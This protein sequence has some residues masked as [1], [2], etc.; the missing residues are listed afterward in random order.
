[1]VVHRPKG[2][3]DLRD[4]IVHGRVTLSGKL[5]PLVNKVTGKAGSL[6]PD[7]QLQYSMDYFNY[8]LL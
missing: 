6:L 7:E 8:F 5:C 4:F 1:M 2:R 3:E